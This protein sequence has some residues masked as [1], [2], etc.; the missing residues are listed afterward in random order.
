MFFF[1]P[2]RV[3]ACLNL[4][5]GVCE[6]CGKGQKFGRGSCYFMP[7]VGRA[8]L[9]QGREKDLFVARERLP[10]FMDEEEKDHAATALLSGNYIGLSDHHAPPQVCTQTLRLVPAT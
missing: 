2:T 6:P 1:R 3:F 7:L 8:Q 9:K 5:L 10:G 4:K